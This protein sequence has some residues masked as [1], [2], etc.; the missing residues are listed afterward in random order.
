MAVIPYQAEF[1]L[2]VV[3]L[4]RQSFQRAM[5]LEEHNR[6]ADLDPQ[7]DYFTTI[8]AEHIHVAMDAETSTLTGFMVLTPGELEHL[9]VHVDYQGRG[10]GSSF[11]Q[12]ARAISPEGLS[13]YTFQKNIRAQAFY[14]S[15]GFVEIG[16]GYA[17]PHNNLWASTR[18]E[19]ADI[20]YRWR[21]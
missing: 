13:L 1:G 5:G 19:L 17:D 9:Y 18:E 7:L 15:N 8:A 20:R 14:E 16:R 2:E 11:L 3:K 4:W 6:S 21:P 12:K 10:L